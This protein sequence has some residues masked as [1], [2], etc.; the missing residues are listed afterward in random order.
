M[1]KRFFNKKLLTIISVAMISAFSIPFTASAAVNGDAN[2]DG[3]L[4]VKDCAFIAHALA[5]NEELPESADYNLD[6]KRNI[7]DAVAIASSLST[8]G[9]PTVNSKASAVLALVNKERAKVGAKP[10]TLNTTL[11]KMADVRAKEIVNTFSHTRPNSTPC[12]SIFD[13]FNIGYSYA[14]ENIA[15]GRATPEETVRDWVN[16][17]GH[18]RN[19]IDT[20][21]TEIG[22]GY[23]Y[24]Y[25]S[26]YHY[27]WVQIFRKP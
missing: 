22:V 19:M 10:L 5:Y 23:Y 4:N 17:E 2:S 24:D 25:N 16:S 27:H 3:K 11:S 12:F 26:P 6:G 18:Y 14:G 13:D 7:I 20:N 8:K 9:D 21:Y 15:A 1:F